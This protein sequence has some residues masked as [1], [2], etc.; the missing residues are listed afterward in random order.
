MKHFQTTFIRRKSIDEKILVLSKLKEHFPVTSNK[1]YTK[2]HIEQLE[3]FN[4]FIFY[5]NLRFH[6]FP[7]RLIRFHIK[8]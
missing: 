5:I 1:L 7:L 6:E 4:Y 2:W 8:I 3:Q